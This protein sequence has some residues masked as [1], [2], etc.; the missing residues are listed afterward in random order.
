MKKHIS[1]QQSLFSFFG[2]LRNIAKIDAILPQGQNLSPP[3]IFR[4]L[5]QHSLL[6]Q[7]G[8][9]IDQLDQ[10]IV[11]VSQDLRL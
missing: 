7:F 10:F 6:R 8:V 4:D 3:V 1:R 9:E 2:C 11:K 5:L